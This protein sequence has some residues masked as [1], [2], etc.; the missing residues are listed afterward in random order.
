MAGQGRYYSQPSYSRLDDP[1][2]FYNRMESYS[3]Q[4]SPQR[5]P[6]RPT[7]YAN[8]RHESPS[9]PTSYADSQ[10]HLPSR[11]FSYADNR[12][13]SYH[14]AHAR[15][16]SYAQPRPESYADSHPLTDSTFSDLPRQEPKQKT[17][18][19][20]NPLQMSKKGSWWRWRDFSRKRKIIVASSAAVFL[21]ILIAIIIGAS[22]YAR[23]SAFSYTQ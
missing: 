3:P 23:Q 16:E 5:S 20:Y 11:P 7:S 12:P 10:D 9:R 14:G 2:D 8:S 21:I 1:T 15:S 19:Q 17:Y 22:V 18:R 4:R 6:T 13:T